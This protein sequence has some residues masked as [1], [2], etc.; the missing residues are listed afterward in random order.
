[1]TNFCLTARVSNN[2]DCPTLQKHLDG[3]GITCEGMKY[4]AE[5]LKVN[6]KLKTLELD[7]NTVGDVSD[8][9]DTLLV[10]LKPFIVSRSLNMTRK[11]PRPL[12]KS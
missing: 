8:T 10:V 4:I 1:M 5:G 12:P 3:N 2:H 9:R 6:R 7:Y 11:E